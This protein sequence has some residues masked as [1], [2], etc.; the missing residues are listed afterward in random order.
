MISSIAINGI[1]LNTTLNDYVITGL[2]GFSFPETITS[3][4]KRGHY[5][6]SVLDDY[7]YA[8]RVLSIE[9]EILC[10][11]VSDYETKRQALIKAF[12]I[13]SGLQTLTI[14]TRNSVVLTSSV[15]V[16]RAVDMPHKKGELIWGS[17]RIELVA[18]FPFFEGTAQTE[19]ISPIVGGGFTLPF[20][21][22][23]SM[24]VGG[25]GATTI[26]NDG[27][28]TCF[29]TL[30]LTGPL[31]TIGIQNATKS[32]NMS[33]AYTLNTSTDQIII[34]TYNRTALYNGAT[35]I[36]QYISGDWITLGSGDNQIKLFAS[37]SGAT[38]SLEVAY[39][40]T[41]LGI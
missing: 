24:A 33:I 30:T 32:Q 31:S 16:R 9:G 29:P 2:S 40:D 15:M 38:A 25:T 28:G 37:T 21:L 12:T 5:D 39:K 34:D 26:T 18:P 1:T 23:L 14:T 8:E 20:A 7:S 41:Y 17:F 35:N 10:D 11:S 27:N 3:I 13:S 36:L 6:G 4:R 19:D 22:P